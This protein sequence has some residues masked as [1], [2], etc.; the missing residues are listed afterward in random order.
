[1]L[2]ANANDARITDQRFAYA[3][4][5]LLICSPKY[6]SGG[7]TLGEVIQTAAAFVI[8]QGAFRWFTDSYG[9]LA[10]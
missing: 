8:V 4:V 6:L 1:M 7:M 2:A 3:R 9:R 10:E 5:A